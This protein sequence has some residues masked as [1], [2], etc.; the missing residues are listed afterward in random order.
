MQTLLL[1]FYTQ[2][3]HEYFKVYII[4][5]FFEP[6]HMS[7]KNYYDTLGVNKNATA[8]EI[9]KAYY[10]VSFCNKCPSRES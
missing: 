10:G 4:F 2:R 8:S 1:F 9:K 6:A 5:V 3:C 7:A